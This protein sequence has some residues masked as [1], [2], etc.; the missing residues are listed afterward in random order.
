MSENANHSR[1]PMIIIFFFL[2][3]FGYCLVIVF[4]ET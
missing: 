4:R 3:R 2:I 1:L